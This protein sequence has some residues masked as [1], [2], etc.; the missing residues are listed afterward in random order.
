MLD[1]ITAIFVFNLLFFI[2]MFL[3]RHFIPLSLPALVIT[4]IISLL[5][6]IFFP[7]MA[8]HLSYP[9]VIGFLLCFILICAIILALVDK[10][11]QPAKHVAE[12]EALN[13]I[14]TGPDMGTSSEQPATVSPTDAVQEKIFEET[15]L[16]KLET[17]EQKVPPVQETPDKI[18]FVQE[19]KSQLFRTPEAS[20]SKQAVSQPAAPLS[21]LKANAHETT[22]TIAPCEL[23][24][25]ATDTETNQEIL[26]QEELKP[27]QY[28]QDIDKP[29]YKPEDEGDSQV[30]DPVEK[31]NAEEPLLEEADLDSLKTN[32]TQ[33]ETAPDHA[34]AI[35]DTIPGPTDNI[36]DTQD[37]IPDNTQPENLQQLIVSGFSSKKTGHYEQA[38][39][40]FNAALQLKPA[41]KLAVLILLE[42][43]EIYK[44]IDQP[45]QA[46]EILKILLIN[47]QSELDVV[48][49]NEI[50]NKINILQNAA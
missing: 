7:Y 39:K 11:L 6:T 46:A 30:L 24:G 2:F 19:N 26:P 33:P 14:I 41:S 1:F 34:P 29:D 16:H 31:S 23:T 10:K 50:K 18:I 3:I 32:T 8:A 20:L 43:S 12:K 28:V 25:G 40:N 17:A 5:C 36:P 13:E 21:S 9:Q 37:S 22:A 44:L 38:I 15:A 48:T 4:G 45:W 35:S 27:N 49:I 47:W 42:I